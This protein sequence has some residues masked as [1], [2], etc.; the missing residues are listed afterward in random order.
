MYLWFRW[1]RGPNSRGP[2]HPL[3]RAVCQRLTVA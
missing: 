3:A 2:N 1:F